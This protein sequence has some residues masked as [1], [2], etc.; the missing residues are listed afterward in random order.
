MNFSSQISVSNREIK[1]IFYFLYASNRLSILCWITTVLLQKQP[2]EVSLKKVFLKFR[3]FQRK[4]L[5]L[6]SLFN[7]VADLFSRE[8]L[9]SLLL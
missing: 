5:L 1:R 6:E 2:S 7:E 9:Q 8:H 4:T 3:K